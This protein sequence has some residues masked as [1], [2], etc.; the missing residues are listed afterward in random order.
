M[1]K[2]IILSITIAVV[3]TI[4]IAILQA[5]ESFTPI[6][7]AK[8]PHGA[9]VVMDLQKDF[10]GDEAR[11]P[12]EKSQVEPM[13][14]AVN[15]IV[16]GSKSLNLEVIYIDTK[17]SKDQWFT[18]WFRNYAV[19]EGTEGVALDERLLVQSKR[20]F[21]KKKQNAFTNKVFASY[22]KERAIGK[23]VICG[24]FADKCVS[25]TARAAKRRGYAVTVLSDGIAA[26]SK[27]T[28]KRTVRYLKRKGITLKTSADLLKESS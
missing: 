9:I 22:L 13:L 24:V 20:L 17:F 12:V 28:I 6:D 25:A 21:T 8:S 5:E 26:G 15:S 3:V 14:K 1:K 4:V 23:L 2:I 11:Y 16:K 10:I 18:N 7:G 19:I 27:Q